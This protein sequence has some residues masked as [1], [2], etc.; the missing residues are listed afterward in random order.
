MRFQ[1]SS[2]EPVAFLESCRK[3]A[4]RL[5]S[6][7]RVF[8]L[9]FTKTLGSLITKPAQ[10]TISSVEKVLRVT[11]RVCVLWCVELPGLRC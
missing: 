2:S 10:N 11:M 9:V 6:G 5:H 3:C 4:G 7:N 1:L 8:P